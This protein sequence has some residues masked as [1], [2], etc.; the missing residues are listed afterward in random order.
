MVIDTVNNPPVDV[1]QPCYGMHESPIIEHYIS[2]LLLKGHIQVD[3]MY[4]WEYIIKSNR[5]YLKFNW[6]L[7]LFVVVCLPILIKAGF[8]Q[9]DRAEQK[10]QIQSAL[11]SLKIESAI[12]YLKLEKLQ[13]ESFRNVTAIGRFMP[14][15]FFLDNQIHQGQFGYEVIQPMRLSSFDIV[16]ISRGWIKGDL[17]RRI[18]PSIQTPKLEIE[19]NGYL[20][21]PSENIQLDDL[22]LD[23]GWPKRMQTADVDT[24][25]KILDGSG[26]NKYQYLLRL[27]SSSVG[28]LQ[29]HWQILRTGP[30]KHIGY[31]V[32]WFSM[33]VLLLVLFLWVSSSKEKMSE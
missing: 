19:V 6:K 30:E 8:W 13:F 16:L 9:L 21:Q 20:Y 31:A 23:D 3:R 25:Y 33:A 32:Q 4:P 14:E 5:V 2:Y 28:A 29:N 7:T 15:I 22:V 26:V 11:A 12:D 17:D 27:D 10:R 1:P 18:L 24:L